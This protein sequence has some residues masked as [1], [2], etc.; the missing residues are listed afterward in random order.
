MRIQ[1]MIRKSLKSILFFVYNENVLN[2]F[3]KSSKSPSTYT[4][5][6]ANNNSHFFCCS[7]ILARSLSI[8]DRVEQGTT[9]CA[10]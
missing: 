8:I 2:N 5:D 4:I 10:V 7:M 3:S 1:K 9:G 6:Q